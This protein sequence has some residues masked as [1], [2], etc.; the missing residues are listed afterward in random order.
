MEE[1][2]EQLFISEIKIER[3][4]H[5]ENIVIP[6]AKDAR[7]HLI[8]TGCNGSGKTSVLEML[9]G[10]LNSIATAA[11]EIARAEKLVKS[12]ETKLEQLEE[13][14][15]RSSKAIEIEKN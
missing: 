1:S 7:K 3:V 6:L 14:E 2:M 11:E 15:K 9:K 5:L 12:Y 8:L 13:S 4:R 10:V